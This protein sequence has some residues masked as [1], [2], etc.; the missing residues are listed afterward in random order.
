[1]KGANFCGNVGKSLR[2]AT[3]AAFLLMAPSACGDDGSSAERDSGPQVGVDAGNQASADFVFDESQIRSFNLTLPEVDWQNLQDNARDELYVSAQLEYEGQTVEN[4]GLRFKGSI[5]SLYICFSGN[6]QVCDKLSMKLKFNEYVSGQRFYGLKRINLHAMESDPS[7]MHDAIGYKLF[8]DQ[9]VYAPRLAYA[10]VLVNGESLGLFIAVEA[11]DGRFTRSRFPDGGEGNLYKEVWPMHNTEAPYI[12]ALKTN[13][14]ENPSA[15]KMLRFA[16]DLMTAGD[17]GFV[18]TL[19]SW[20][21]VDML[22]KY[23]AVDRLIDHWDGIVGW[24]CSGAECSNH[25]YYWYE[26]STEDKLW[27]VPWDLDHSLEEP[28]RIRANFGMPDWDA[29]GANC[30]PIPLFGGFLMGRAPSCDPIMRRLVTLLWDEYKAATNLL[31]AGD[32]ASAAMDARI[33]ALAALIAAEV[34]ADQVSTQT[35]AEWQAAVQALKNSVN[36]KRAYIESKL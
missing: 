5:G 10:R 33:D 34:E 30:D 28:N 17:A 31:L 32:F 26:S 13:E 27:L 36:A 15:D 7:K 4:I 20:T 2:L 35:T 19:R 23:M 11:I 25:N 8:R 6:V 14:D 29:V 12:A 21:D 9:G 16:Q 24:Y 3:L 18:E 1:M 22:M